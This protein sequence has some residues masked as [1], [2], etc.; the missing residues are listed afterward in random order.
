MAVLDQP[1][2]GLDLG[3][4]DVGGGIELVDA[5][6]RADIDAGAVL[7]IDAGLGDDGDTSHDSHLPVSGTPDASRISHLGP[8]W[9][10]TA[11][12]ATGVS[13]GAL[14]A[15]CEPAHGLTVTPTVV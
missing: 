5:L 13:S 14:I 9:H 6:H 12:C 15:G 3:E 10:R 1:V 4:Q 8:P 11:G 7:H 2:A